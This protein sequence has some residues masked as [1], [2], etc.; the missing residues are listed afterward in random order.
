MA[1]ANRLFQFELWR[2]RATETLSAAFGSRF[3]QT[4]IGSCLLRF[5]VDLEKEINLYHPRGNQ[6][7]NSLVNGINAYTILDRPSKS[8]SYCP[9]NFAGWDLGLGSGHQK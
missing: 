9:M 6:I 5:Q 2:R 7:I 8:L 4:D 1:A 3:L